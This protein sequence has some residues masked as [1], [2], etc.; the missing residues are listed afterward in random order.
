MILELLIFGSGF[1]FGCI[2]SYLALWESVYREGYKH[3]VETQLVK[4]GTEEIK[5]II[6]KVIG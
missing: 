3:G 1:G 6:S 5:R 2:V 4:I